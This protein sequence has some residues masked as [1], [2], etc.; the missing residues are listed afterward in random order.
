MPSLGEMWRRRRINIRNNL[1]S[2][3]FKDDFTKAQF[4]TKQN[5][6]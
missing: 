6:H 4:F 3:S 2:I 1:G 5:C